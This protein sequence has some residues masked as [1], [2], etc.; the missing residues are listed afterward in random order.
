MNR[1]PCAFVTFA[2][3][4]T[5]VAVNDRLL[6]LLQL[7]RADVEGRSID[8]ILTPGSR[9]FH[10][11]HFFPMLKLQGTAEEVYVVLRTKE[12]SAIPTLAYATSRGEVNDCVFAPVLRRESYQ[13]E[14]ARAR[15][16]LIAI[17]GHD[18]RV[19]L[20][21][22]TLGAETLLRLETLSAPGQQIALSMLASARRAARMTIDLLDFARARFAGGIPVQRQPIDLRLIA[23]K[24]IEEL[25]TIHPDETIELC[26]RG[27][28][29]GSWDPDRAAQVVANLVSNALAHGTGGAVVVAL[30]GRADEVVLEVRNAADTSVDDDLFSAFRHGH[31]SAGI[32]L[33]LFIVREVV[34]AHG[35]SVTATAASGEFRVR[36]LW[37]RV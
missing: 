4:G 26:A 1:L 6:A 32:G 16:I 35:G 23:R 12:G 17:L 20:T 22:V 11:T 9:V 29:H 8:V 10:Q 24:V 33:G 36:A 21:S 34:R 30:E 31:G 13:N 7:D 14:L 28:C 18:L 27:D 25:R 37:P 5:I 15:E 19:P 3:D 2:D